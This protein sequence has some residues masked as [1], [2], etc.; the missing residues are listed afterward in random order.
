MHWNYTWKNSR[1]DVSH[2]LRDVCKWWRERER[3]SKHTSMMYIPEGCGRIRHRCF[4]LFYIRK[5]YWTCFYHLTFLSWRAHYVVSL[6]FNPHTL[7]EQEIRCNQ[8]VCVCWYLFQCTL[9]RRTFNLHLALSL[10]AYLKWKCFTLFISLAL[11]R[12]VVI[13][14][15]HIICDV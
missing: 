13:H 12:V 5:S 3:K 7:A 11:L 14:I 10:F 2:V 4:S 9:P 1:R 6:T 15:T 8:C